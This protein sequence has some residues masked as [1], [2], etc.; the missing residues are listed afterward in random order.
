MVLS[1]RGLRLSLTS[2]GLEAGEGADV[3]VD[4]VID[5]Y[6]LLT[7][8]NGD[9]LIT[10]DDKQLLLNLRRFLLTQGEIF[11]TTEQDDFLLLQ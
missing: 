3:D 4:V 1:V 7:A 8:Q 11:L 2:A 6:N 10:Q 9:L 5:F